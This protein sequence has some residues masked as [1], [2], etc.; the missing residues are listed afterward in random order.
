MCERQSCELALLLC[1]K[2]DGEGDK[3]DIMLVDMKIE[4]CTLTV[5]ERLTWLLL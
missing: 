1:L 4:I 2:G 5:A 3:R